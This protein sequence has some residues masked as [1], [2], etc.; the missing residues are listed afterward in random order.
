[1]EYI[2]PKF[3]QTKHK[4]LVSNLQV[5]SLGAALSVS[6]P[7]ESAS[8]RNATISISAKT[9]QLQAVVDLLARNISVVQQLVSTISNNIG[10]RDA[11]NDQL[12]SALES[13]RDLLANFTSL[14]SDVDSIRSDILKV[15]FTYSQHST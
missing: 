3:V 1:M 15:S 4:S 5:G 11:L 14:V 12:K 2:R 13:A 7:S 10:S 8:L 6:H 9:K